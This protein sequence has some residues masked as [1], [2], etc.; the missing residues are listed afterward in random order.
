MNKKFNV[1][2]FTQNV[3][4]SNTAVTQIQPVI[5]YQLGDGWSISAGDLQFTCD[6]EA[7]RWVDIPIG[8]RLG[9]VGKLGGL[10]TR[11]AI[12]PQYNIK[13]HRGLEEWSVTFTFNAP[14][15]CF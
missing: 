6:W 12:N 1:G 2:L 15:P 3:F 14:F 9:K 8:F 7:A 10:P 4:W 5:A 13:N 11:F